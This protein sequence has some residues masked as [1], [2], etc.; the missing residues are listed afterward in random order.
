MNIIAYTLPGCP[1]CSHLR[2][3]FRRAEV[4]YKEVTV[5]NDM[6]I[7]EFN[8]LHP[9]VSSFPFVVIDGE[10][11]G[12]L[13]EVVRMFVKNGLVSSSKKA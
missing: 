4:E 1:S 7:S 3:L 13:V 6:T 10:R 2:E 5:K 11:V 9:N 12:G 8:S